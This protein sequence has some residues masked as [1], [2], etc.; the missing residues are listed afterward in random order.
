MKVI[1]IPGF[2]DSS[3]KFDTFANILK[4]HNIECEIL[5]YKNYKKFGRL[6]NREVFSKM[7]SEMDSNDFKDTIIISY[8]MG[9]SFVY[10]Y[11]KS[12]DIKP[13]KLI[14]INP[15]LESVKNPITSS[16]Y[17]ILDM[18]YQ[19]QLLNA[20]SSANEGLFPLID[21]ALL[22]QHYNKKINF[23]KK[24][25]LDATF[26]WSEKDLICP[27]EKYE[28]YKEYF[29]NTKLITVNDHHHNWLVYNEPIEKYLIPQI[30]SI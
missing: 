14:F 2:W 5:D 8:S 30:K 9:A 21:V 4:D 19:G 3:A 12:H 17:R 28:T 29:K 10:D 23:D 27:I 1:Y 25:D 18:Y 20:I 26:I 24:L 22:Q 16:Y 15:L 13:A 6:L 7:L 11:L